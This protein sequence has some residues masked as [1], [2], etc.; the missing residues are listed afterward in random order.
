MEADLMAKN[1]IPET[2]DWPERTKNWYF[3]VG[4]SLDPETGKITRNAKLQ[5][6][7]ERLQFILSAKES[8]VFRPNREKDELTYTIGTAEH[9]GR[10]RGKGTVLWLIGFPNDRDTYKSRQRK[11]DEIAERIRALESNVLETKEAL[12]KSQEE[13]KAIRNQMQEEIKRQ[14]EI[15]LSAQKGATSGPGVNIS[16]QCNTRVFAY[17]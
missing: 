11:K 3:G 10:T 6:A 2:A 17:I 16:P 12:L 15:A 8:G 14:V 13:T 9:G 4:G 1:I 5:E 7:I